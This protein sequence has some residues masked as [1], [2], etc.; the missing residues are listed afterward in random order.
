MLET[1]PRDLLLDKYNDLVITDDLQWSKGIPGVMQ[2]CRI[3]LQ[4]F[5]GEWFLNLLVGI[6]YWGQILGQKP[7]VAI[8]AAGAQFTAALLSIPDVLDVTKMDVTYD[9]ATRTLTVKWSVRCLFGNT[10][11][12]T[13]SITT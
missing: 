1:D 9:G 12:D 10:P 2:E 7:A 5:K 6:D 4:M 13:L 3:R 11:V 8:A